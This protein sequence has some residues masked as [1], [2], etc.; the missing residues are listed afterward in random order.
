MTPLLLNHMQPWH[1][2]A[3][4]T[5]IALITLVLLFVSNTRLGISS[6]FDDLCSLALGQP[7]FTRSSVRSSRRWRLP[8]LL[9]L[10]LGGVA[11]AA[12]SGGWHPTWALG[13]FD[14]RIGWGPVGKLAWM[15]GGGLLIGFGTRLGGGC[16]SGHAIF[17]VSNFEVP[18]LL[19]TISFMAGGIA[20]TQVIYHFVLH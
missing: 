17:G 2:L 15:F 16:T 8:F 13:M 18:S 20:T 4:G 11:S 10:F 7:Y 14:Q 6:G 12:F 9:G 3:A 1:W 19:T 5:A